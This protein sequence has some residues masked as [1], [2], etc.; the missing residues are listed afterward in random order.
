TFGGTITAPYWV[1]LVR[2]GNTFSGY[3]SGDGAN[4]ILV[5][6]DTITTMATGVYIG[7]AVTAHNNTILCTATLDNV[8]LTGTPGNVPPSVSLTPPSNG[9]S[10]TAPP[11]ITITASASDS[12]GTVRKVDFYN[13]KST[14][15]N[16]SHVS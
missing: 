5:G 2:T 13:R 6:T 8:S 16:S 10:F 12:D 1:K 15:L 9:A 3:Q 4:W 7:I 14:H 11:S